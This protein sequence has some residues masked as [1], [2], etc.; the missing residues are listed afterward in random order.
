MVVLAAAPQ[1]AARDR[2]VTTLN[3]SGRVEVRQAS[4]RLDQMIR[5]GALGVADTTADTLLPWRTHQR[6]RQLY[7]G[8]PVF[9]GDLTRE[10]DESSAVSVFGQ[11]YGA[12][13]LDVQPALNPLDAKSIVERLTGVELGESRVPS[14]VVLPTDE[15]GYALAWD[16]QVATADDITRFFIDAHSGEIAGRYSNLQTQASAVGKG[17]G[18][19]G[20][21][22]KVM[23]S[24]FG[25]LYYTSD[26]MR[27]PAIYTYDMKNNIQ[28]MQDV[29]NG[30]VML[31]PGWSD[32]ASSTANVWTDGAAVDAQVY[33]GFTY[34]YYYKRMGRRGLNDR[35]LAMRMFVHP[36]DRNAWSTMYNEYSLYYTNAF[37]A[38]GGYMVFGEGLPPSVTAGGRHW[39]YT[40][41]ALDV[42]AHELTHGVTDYS[43]DLIYRDESGAL[44]EAF[45]DIMATAVEFYFQPAAADV[46]NG[47]GI[48]KADYLCGED[49]VTP[50]AIRSLA[51]P[52]MVGYPD[53]YSNKRVGTSDNG[54]VH[55][56]STIGSH[57][58]F[59]AVEGGTNA[60]SRVA[61]TGVGAANRAQI[62]KVFYRAF[63]YKLPS[64]ATYSTARAATIQSARELYGSG[65]AAETA[66]R[67]AWDAVGV[68]VGAIPGVATADPARLSE[69]EGRTAGVAVARIPR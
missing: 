7:K 58:F 25:S 1:E 44:S 23:A 42:V 5:A 60:T 66:V 13:D 11:T 14:L 56:N 16:I 31:A 48:L 67:Q 2:R 27:P 12:I 50:T 65:S 46:R 6:L 49:V 28:R 34:D 69:G 59:L 30:R 8:V 54:Y 10:Y 19:L 52:A 22:K 29:L 21:Q 40:S 9:G 33:A 17:T 3:A 38:G 41:A 18:V 68:D 15:G 32:M 51:N 47:S 45:S 20:D 61:V 36:I 64:N 26:R 63:V 35:D 37:Y 53:H 4:S 24:F 55:A 43:S 39:N 57:A 62:E